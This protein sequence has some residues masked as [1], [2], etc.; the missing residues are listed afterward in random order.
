[1]NFSLILLAGDISKNPGPLTFCYWNLG[2]LPTENFVKKHL[3]E[4]FLSV[5]DFDIVILGESHL[6]SKID[7][8]DLEIDG[9][10]I[11]RCDHPDEKTRGG[12]A[13]LNNVPKSIL[14]AYILPYTRK[15]FLLVAY[16][17]V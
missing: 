4:A 3:L 6:T 16:L 5:N 12:I 17:R 8:N 2:G 14:I 13:V 1:M 15:S 10:T 9:Y 7:D 11:E